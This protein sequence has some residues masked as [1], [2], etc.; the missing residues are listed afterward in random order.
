MDF[1]VEESADQLLRSIKERNTVDYYEDFTNWADPDEEFDIKPEK[2]FVSAFLYKQRTQIM[3]LDLNK[4]YGVLPGQ[5]THAAKFMFAFGMDLPSSLEV[6]KPDLQR[7]LY[8]RQ[9]KL[10][11]AE[12]ERTALDE[13]LLKDVKKRVPSDKLFSYAD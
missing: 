9:L 4:K 10:F 8:A 7:V 12:N 3:N 5:D 2:V 6:Q 11:Q 1:E 13:Q